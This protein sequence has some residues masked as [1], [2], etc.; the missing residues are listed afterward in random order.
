MVRAAGSGAPPVSDPDP[1][2][3]VPRPESAHRDPGHPCPTRDFRPRWRW[4]RPTGC[5]RPV[6][7][8]SRQRHVD[9]SGLLHPARR[10]AQHRPHDRGL[11][12][13]GPRHRLLTLGWDPCPSWSTSSGS[14]SAGPTRPVRR[15]VGHGVD[16]RPARRRRPQRL[17]QVDAAAAAG[18][19][20]ASPRRASCGG[21]AA[22]G[23]RFL[24]Q[25]PTLPP[26]TVRGGGGRRAGRRPPSSTGSAW[27][28]WS[29]PTSPPCRAARPS[30]WPW[31][32][33]L[34][35]R[36]RPA[37]ARRAH[38]PPR[39]RRHRLAGG[40]PGRASAAGWCWSPTT[41]TC[42]TGSPPGSSSSTGARA[43]STTAATPATSR[44]G[45]SGRSGRRRPRPSRRNLARSEL[46]WLR[47]GAPARTRKPKARIDAGHRHR[48][49]R[50]RPRPTPARRSTSAV[51]RGGTTPRLGDKVVELHGV[52]HR[53]G[54]GPP[55]LFRGLD[56]ALEPRRAARRSSGPNGAGQVDAARHPRRPA[57][58]GRG[59]VE[60]GPTVRLGYYDQVGGD[61]DPTQRVREAVAG[62]TAQPD[63]EQARL[64]ERFWFDADAQWAPDRHALGRR[65]PPAAAAARAGRPAQRAAARR[66]HQR[67]RPRHAPGAR[68]LPRG[69]ARVRWS[70]S[71]TTGPSSSAPSRTCWSSTARA[72]P[73]TPPAATPSTRTPAAGR[74]RVGPGPP[75]A[76]RRPRSDASAA[77]PRHARPHG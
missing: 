40:P 18:R 34:R 50:G 68:G 1:D 41:A 58:A 13:P 62:P 63:W 28:A 53:F 29:T 35:G 60:H 21:A 23:S 56:L 55:W 37:G 64:L 67:P 59:P 15:P 27:A 39:H 71:A 22:C 30:G 46:A 9:P 38:Q 11:H 3:G 17:R 43:T 48:R 77:P 45:P 69:L 31:P 4:G 26:G 51:R 20:A 65:A 44:P 72:R 32:G 70:W 6:R 8:Q 54:D 2:R 66:A 42:S 49:G 14:P 76:G 19:G 47:R 24:D 12:S 75:R 25:D 74:R 61:L 33:L 7:P 36:G 73:P 16:R 10:H 57:A 52:G 5:R